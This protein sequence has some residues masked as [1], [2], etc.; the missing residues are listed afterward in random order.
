MAFNFKQKG[1]TVMK[2]RFTPAL[3]G[4]K[5][6][7]LCLLLL[8]L[9]LLL[10][11]AA[12]VLANSDHDDD[13]KKG[14]KKPVI[15]FT[16]ADPDT[17]KI[18]INGKNLHNGKK[19]PKVFLGI[20][21]KKGT[22]HAIPLD[23]ESIDDAGKQ[24]IAILPDVNPMTF[25]PFQNGTYLITVKRGGKRHS[26]AEFHV[27]LGLPPTP[28]TEDRVVFVTSFN[29]NG[30]L[31]GLAGADGICNQVAALG[32]LT[33]GTY[34]AWL[35]PGVGLPALSRLNP[36][37]GRFVNTNGDLVA[38]DVTGLNSGLLNPILY[39]QNGAPNGLNIDPWTGTDE[40]GIGTSDSCGLWTLD[41]RSGLSGSVGRSTLASESFPGWTFADTANCGAGHPLYCFQ[42]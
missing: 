22:S 23:V 9:V 16:S 25:L 41:G 20:R 2:I 37:P 42:Q 40:D 18:D 27:V 10:T 33:P 30:G 38:A 34:V 14:K 5:V 11:F 28:A 6:S 17:G 4:Q 36:R 32:P 1:S 8:T 39:N 35:A 3:I 24:V 29:Y 31:G 19:N 12:P 26:S 13:K 7:G 21:T 15:S